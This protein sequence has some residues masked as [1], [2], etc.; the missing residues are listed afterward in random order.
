MCP[1]RF[2]I[3]ILL[4]MRNATNISLFVSHAFHIHIDDLFL[5]LVFLFQFRSDGLWMVSFSIVKSFTLD[6]QMLSIRFGFLF[7][8]NSFFFSRFSAMKFSLL[9]LYFHQCNPNQFNIIVS[10]SSSPIEFTT[11]NF[12]C[13]P[14]WRVQHNV[15]A[16]LTCVSCNKVVI[17][18]QTIPK[19]C[20]YTFDVRCFWFM[21][22]I[23]WYRHRHRHR[24]ICVMNLH[25]ICLNMC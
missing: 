13:W 22:C 17:Q 18:L 8:W 16:F 6:S 21:V 11:G 20:R 14:F 3:Y 5:S 19:H 25:K 4:N 24:P 7:C 23:V 9:L 1:D 2:Y 10:E 15:D 12:G